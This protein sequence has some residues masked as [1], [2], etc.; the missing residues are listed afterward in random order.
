MSQVLS[1]MQDAAA[2]TQHIILGNANSNSAVQDL[3]T[4]KGNVTF[5]LTAGQSSVTA[6]NVPA[7]NIQ[8]SDDNVTFT[9]VT[10]GAFAAVAN[11]MN[12][13]NCSAQMLTFDVRTLKRY[14]Y[15]TATVLG[16][17]PNVPLSVVAIAQKERV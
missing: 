17:N 6:G 16:T 4:Y 15:V 3:A 2:V 5:L 13:N 8:H 10:G 1:F 9:A 14:V 7:A 11:T 12:A